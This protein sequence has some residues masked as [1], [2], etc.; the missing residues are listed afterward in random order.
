M[1][2]TDFK[3]W[4]IVLETMLKIAVIICLAILAMGLVAQLERI[5]KKLDQIEHNKP[6]TPGAGGGA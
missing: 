5:E 6:G 1:S 3:V 4:L 2:A